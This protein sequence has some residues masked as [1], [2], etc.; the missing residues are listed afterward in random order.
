MLISLMK[1]LICPYLEVKEFLLYPQSSY[2][3]VIHTRIALD[4]IASSVRS[5]FPCVIVCGNEKLEHVELST[6]LVFDSFCELKK[7]TFQEIFSKSEQ[8]ISPD[9]LKVLCES[10]LGEVFRQKGRLREYTYNQLYQELLKYTIFTDGN[11]YV[12]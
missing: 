4:K 7:S 2:P 3:P 8:I 10:R 1:S 12:S 9:M 5:G 6:L 11:L